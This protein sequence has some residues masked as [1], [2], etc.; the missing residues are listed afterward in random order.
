[1]IEVGECNLRKE[2]QTLIQDAEDVRI[3]KCCNPDDIVKAVKMKLSESINMIVDNTDS[4]SNCSSSVELG[5]ETNYP[6]SSD[7]KDIKDESSRPI[8][9][10]N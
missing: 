10:L 3:P 6:C 9:I 7:V 2:F 4:D 1:M 5:S 8:P